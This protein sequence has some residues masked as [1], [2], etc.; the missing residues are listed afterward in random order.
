MNASKRLP[1]TAI[2]VP[3]VYGSC[4]FY[5][6]KKAHETATHKWTLFVR[7]PNG[8]DLSAFISKVAF[9]LHESFAEPV[10]I[11]EKPPY[12]VT[13]LGWGEFAA[14]IRLFFRDPEEQPV[15]IV[16][17]IKLYPQ[18]SNQ[19]QSQVASSVQQ[20]VKKPVM[21]ETYDE[22]VFVEPTSAF[23]QKLMTYTSPS[24]LLP[25]A[26]QNQTSFSQQTASISNQTA[27]MASGNI[28]TGSTMTN[29]PG[30]D[31]AASTAAASGG[32]V[33]NAMAEHYTVFDEEKDV[34]AIMG[35]QQHL[36]REI[37]VA[38]TK[39]AALKAE[40]EYLSSI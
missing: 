14:K 26:N 5:L 27:I 40:Q 25:V 7:G 16:H 22:V 36:L 28:G 1:S 8:E 19:Q 38:K 10:R 29:T 23:R 33:I 17:I 20:N 24:N 21:S 30:T 18:N 6:G 3:I 4:A 12:E 11:I 39:L 31:L 32:G 13:E 2:S 37:D 35:A 9:S 15:D 34:I